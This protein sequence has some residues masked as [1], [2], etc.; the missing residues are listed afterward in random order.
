MPGGMMAVREG[1]MLEEAVT[2]LAEGMTQAVVMTV[3]P[4]TATEGAGMT[5]EIP[6][7]MR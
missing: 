7:V 3:R 1:M 5:E 6:E 4:A 2:M